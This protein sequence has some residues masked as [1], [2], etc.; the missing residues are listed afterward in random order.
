MKTKKQVLKK[1]YNKNKDIVFL[2]V[3][4]VIA[5]LCFIA[6]K[7]IFNSEKNYVIVN[8]TIDISS[9][10][11]GYFLKNETVLDIDSQKSFV[12]IA[13]QD[14]R[15]SKNETIAIYKN[16]KYEEYT[17]KIEEKDKEIKEAMQDLP[18]VYSTDI[19]ILDTQIDDYIKS[20]KTNTSSYI[21]MQESKNAID[22]LVYKRNV[23][24]SNLSPVGATVRELIEQRDA[25]VSE[26]EK[27]SDNIK[28]T[29]AGLISYKLDGLE[30]S[31]NYNNVLNMTI[32]DLSTLFEKIDKNTVSKTGIKISDNYAAY[33]VVKEKRGQNDEYIKEGKNYTVK[34]TDKNNEK[35]TITLKK[36]LQND[37]YNYLI[38]SLSNG[39]ENFAD[40][41]NGSINIIWKSFEGMI[42]P[43]KA[44]HQDEGGY[45]VYVIVNGEYK[46]Q[47]V[48][49]TI[50]DDN[51]SIITNLEDSDIDIEVYDRILISK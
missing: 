16:E 2:S 15:V 33:I 31:F 13:E 35:I 21:K 10:T 8:G 37:E 39:I 20:A 47:Y 41:R 12:P 4:I 43:T 28:S 19:S 46:K 27:V 36:L 42:V 23:I 45:Y 49:V 18:A 29:V 32:D 34:F 7:Y 25:L 6:Y 3:I 9:D 14:E 44:I 1:V 38:F 11:T 22:E 5:F 48:N 40:D 24:V 51:M 50:T 17:K 30:D 26:S